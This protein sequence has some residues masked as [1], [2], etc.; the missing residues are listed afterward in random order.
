MALIPV[1]YLFRFFV[2]A[3]R[4]AYKSNLLRRFHLPV[5]VIVVGNISVGGTGKSPLVIWISDYLRAQGY[6]PGIIIRGYG[7]KGETWP[8]QV[9]PDSDAFMVG[10]EAVLLAKR[11]DSPV[12]VGPDKIACAEALIKHNQ[13]DIIISDDGLQH[14]RMDRDIEI[15][16]IDGIRRQGN[17]YCLPAGPLR[18]PVSRIKEVDL[19]VTNGAAGRGEFSMQYIPTELQ[20][21]DNANKTMPL[22]RLH[23]ETVHAVA[24]I[25]NP[26][27]FFELLRG[28]GLKVERHAFPDHHRFEPHELQFNDDLPVIVTEKD[29]VKCS[30]FNIDGLWMLPIETELPQA[31]E[32]RL[33]QLLNKL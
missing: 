16:V 10:D 18:E 3:R 20:A 27:R 30:H 21:I 7:G 9:R 12:A 19:V 15:V 8:Q 26:D 33:Q 25:G 14:Y 4:F 31:F 29:A 1:S 13:C 2:E 5:P 17:G 23:G 11:C 6:N 32:H 24:A 28:K 22:D